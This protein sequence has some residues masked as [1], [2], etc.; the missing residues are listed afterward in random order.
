MWP[1]DVH[2]L[3][4]RRAKPATDLGV[5]GGE[6]QV[7]AAFQDAHL[8]PRGPRGALGIRFCED[9]E[10]HLGRSRYLDRQWPERTQPASETQIDRDRPG[11]QAQVDPATGER[12]AHSGSVALTDRTVAVRVAR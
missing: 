5:V 9:V 6:S 3:H 11:H 7:L 8:L 4:S 2:S 12:A 10:D 1:L